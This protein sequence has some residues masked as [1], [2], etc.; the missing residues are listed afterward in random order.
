MMSHD[1]PNR[2]ERSQARTE[3]VANDSVLAHDARSLRVERPTL[4]QDVIGHG[5]LADI[6]K[7]PAA[8]ERI[9]IAA[10]Q[11]KRAA[12]RGGI[13]RE[14]LTVTAGAGV[15]RLDRRAQAHDDA[16]GRFQFIGV[17]LE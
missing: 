8:L 6:V 16:L 1:R 4:Q 12:E 17:A 10:V 7:N 3:R 13:P 14:A 11:S 2:P 15:A 9:E 5:D